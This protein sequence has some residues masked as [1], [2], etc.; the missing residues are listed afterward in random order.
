MIQM[1]T[2]EDGQALMDEIALVKGDLVELKKQFETLV[3]ELKQK[4]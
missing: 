2:A 3:A 1:L 4:K